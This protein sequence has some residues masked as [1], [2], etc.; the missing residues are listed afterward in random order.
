[1]SSFTDIG[2]LQAKL[3]AS[4]SSDECTDAEH[5]GRVSRETLPSILIHGRNPR[6][7]AALA[8]GCWAVLIEGGMTM[9]ISRGAQRYLET[10]LDEWAQF[11]APV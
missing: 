7:Q 1:M 2:G 8:F 5:L 10:N 6:T 9:D 3:G 11:G 4:F